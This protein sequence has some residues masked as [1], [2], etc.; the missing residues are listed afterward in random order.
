MRC[1]Q[2]RRR[3][4]RRRARSDPQELREEL[5]AEE[6]W[7]RSDRQHEVRRA[8]RVAADVGD[9]EEGAE[10]IDQDFDPE[11]DRGRDVLRVPD[12]ESTERIRRCVA[13]RQ[14]ER[15]VADLRHRSDRDRERARSTF[16]PKSG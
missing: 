2:T 4:R 16:T 5:E 15:R 3:T 8:D 13:A 7:V 14:R 11:H 6:R 9:D 10:M 1:R 12:Q